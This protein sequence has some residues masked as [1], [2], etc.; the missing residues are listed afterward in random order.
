MFIGIDHGTT[1]MRFAGESGQFK[2]SREAAKDFTISALS[3]L[4]PIDKIEGIALCYSMGDGISS[5]TSIEQSEEP[6]NHQ[7]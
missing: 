5:I 7:P 4:C 6:G 2:L 3:R 1:A